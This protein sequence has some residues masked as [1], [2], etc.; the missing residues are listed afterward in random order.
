[1]KL[2]AAALVLAAAIPTVLA[3]GAPQP[4]ELSLTWELTIEADMLRSIRLKLPGHERPQTFWY[5]RF[6]VINNSESEQIFIPEF[7][8]YTDTGQVIKV[9]QD[10]PTA[11]FNELKKIYNDPLMMSM[12]NVTGKILRGEDNGKRG[13]A[14]WPD[15]DPKAAQVDV[16]VGGLSG[17]TAEIEL[18][19]PIETTE[20]DDEGN[21]QTVKRDKI[22]LNKTLQLSYSI[23][24][25]AAARAQATVKLLAQK[26]VMR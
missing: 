26:W 3:A 23:P 8:L 17:E 22:I 1:M 19:V 13:V 18:P 6:T 7:V 9:G 10:V 5:M 2:S 21:K 12:V 15:F 20:Y 14:I 25:E 4:S 24:A 11:V 16:F